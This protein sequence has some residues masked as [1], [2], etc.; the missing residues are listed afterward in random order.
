MREDNC[1]G[2]LNLMDTCALGENPPIQ[3]LLDSGVV[4]C[5]IQFLRMDDNPALQLEAAEALTNITS[6]YKSEHI[7]YV[8]E[9]GV[10][11]ILI[12]L[13]SSRNESV[14]SQA[15]WALGNIAGENDVKYRDIILAE[16]AKVHS[17]P[18]YKQQRIGLAS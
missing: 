3:Q 16:G 15:A 5:L 4:P 10:V 14:V 8:V 2:F 13:L 7:R 11:P 6:S 1:A 18:C 9:A 12:R 17:L